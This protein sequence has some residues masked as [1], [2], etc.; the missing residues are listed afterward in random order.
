MHTHVHS[1]E[2]PAQTEGRLIRRASFYDGLANIMPFGQISRFR[3][4][5]VDLAVFQSGHILLDVGCGTG[6]ATIPAKTWPT[7]FHRI[8]YSVAD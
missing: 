8:T 2:S 4:M 1:A 3:Q 7:F 5:T 6:G